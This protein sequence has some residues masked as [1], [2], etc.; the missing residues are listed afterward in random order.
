MSAAAGN[1][2]AAALLVR[3]RAR[4]QVNHV[5]SIHRFRFGGKQRAGTGRKARG[6]F[7]I[8]GLVGALMLFGVGNIAYQSIDKDALFGQFVD[9]DFGDGKTDA[10]GWIF[11]LGYVP[12]K[13]WGLNA[14]YFVN[15]LNK[16]VGT[17]IDY[18][19][20]QL[21]LNYKF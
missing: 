16:D 4:Q 17:E 1:L 15:T 8:G 20:L 7:L 5:L 13:N 6:G 3:L 21:D 2:R 9:S 11:R 12:V 14:Q 19:R 10:E 18:K